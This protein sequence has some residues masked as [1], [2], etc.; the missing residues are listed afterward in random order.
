MEEVFSSVDLLS[1]KQ[2]FKKVYK[3]D[4]QVVFIFPNGLYL[5]TLN[6]DFAKSINSIKLLI[7]DPEEQIKEGDHYIEVDEIQMKSPVSGAVVDSNEDIENCIKKFRDN[8]LSSYCLLVRPS[9]KCKENFSDY[10]VIE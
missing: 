10:V 7:K 4:Q 6:P 5:I 2:R 8:V 3:N 1:M 9:R